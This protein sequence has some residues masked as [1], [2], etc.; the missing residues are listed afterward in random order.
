MGRSWQCG[1]VQVDFNLPERFNLSYVNSQG[2]KSRPVIIHRAIYGSFERFL[3]IV[4]EHHKG[5]LPFWL[6]PVQ[7]KV[8]TI[9]DEQKPYAATVYNTFRS[10]GYRVAQDESSDPISGKIKLAQNEQVPWMVVLGQKEVENNT[11]TLRYRD[12]KQEF[13]LTLDQLL[14]KAVAANE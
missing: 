1:T 3:A 14:Q 9:T 2:T 8:L 4:L 11:V 13:G 5:K 10:H 6:S 12:G 7:I